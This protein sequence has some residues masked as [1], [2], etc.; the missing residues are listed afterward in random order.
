MASGLKFA[1]E[2]PDEGAAAAA[3]AGDEEAGEVV[4]TGDM[5]LEEMME[6]LQ[7]TTKA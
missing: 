3:A 7:A 5:S 2:K 1:Y 4:D 6:Q